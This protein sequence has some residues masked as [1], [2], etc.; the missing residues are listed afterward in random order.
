MITSALDWWLELSQQSAYPY[1]S[2]L[3]LDIFSIP[4]MSAE[5]ERVFSGA[6]RTISWERVRLGASTVEMTECLKSWIKSRL[7][8]GSI[9][10]L[11]DVDK[12]AQLAEDT[13]I[14]L[15]EDMAGESS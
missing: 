10:T 4:P 12:L 7:S 14:P 13:I 8:Y 5:A 3:A 2:R 9:S 15:E 11:E 6:R 1:L